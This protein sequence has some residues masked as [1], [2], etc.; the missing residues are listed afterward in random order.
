MH[1]LVA[2]ILIATACDASQQPATVEFKGLV[3]SFS[4]NS[5]YDNTTC[6]GRCCN[7]VEVHS[8]SSEC[9]TDWAQCAKRK[10]DSALPQ[11][12]SAL[13][14]GCSAWVPCEQHTRVS[15]YIPWGFLFGLS[16]LLLC[17]LCLLSWEK[18]TPKGIGAGIL[19]F[20]ASKILFFSFLLVPVS[21]YRYWTT[22]TE[23]SLEFVAYQECVA[24][25]KRS[26]ETTSRPNGYCGS[27]WKNSASHS[28]FCYTQTDEWRRYHQAVT[29]FEARAY[30]EWA[31]IFVLGLL[32]YLLR[33]QFNCFKN[34]IVFEVLTWTWRCYVISHI[35]F[36]VL[37]AYAAA[38]M[39]HTVQLM[40]DV[41]GYQMSLVLDF[42]ILFTF[43]A[44]FDFLYLLF[45]MCMC[46]RYP[47]AHEFAEKEALSVRGLIGG[48][49]KLG[50]VIPATQTDVKY[51]AL[52]HVNQDDLIR[53]WAKE[54]KRP[55]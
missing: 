40:A 3:T 43:L 41:A 30:A 13:I 24:Y 8:S 15:F 28:I 34:D 46:I 54:K 47:A 18:Q 51:N 55:V 17:V 33:F 31:V 53:S 20:I 39:S 5:F 10:S 9:N 27:D 4:G 22:H 37:D 35:P 12:S 7:K 25:C 36:L 38:N 14:T 11:C 52:L 19:I 49:T 42:R 21:D 48:L 2:L 23:T 1:C 44:V 32:R 16:M 6:A 50:S 26:D 29:Y 45:A